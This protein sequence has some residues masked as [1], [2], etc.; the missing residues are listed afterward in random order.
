MEEIRNGN[1]DEYKEM[2]ASKADLLE[3][4][5]ELELEHGVGNV[6][7]E[8]LAN[9]QVHISTTNFKTQEEIIDGHFWVETPDG[10]V[11]N[12]LTGAEHVAKFKERGETAVY[13]PANPADEERFIAKKMLM[14]QANI[15]KV[16]EAEYYQSLGNKK[17]NGFDW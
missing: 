1:H 12:D 7:V 10:E 2:T 5:A 14:V 3:Y 16:G 15:D 13:L 9:G 17:M 6:N 4:I 8:I 11:Y